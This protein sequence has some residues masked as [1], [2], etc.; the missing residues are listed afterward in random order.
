MKKTKEIIIEDGRDK[1]KKFRITEM[2]AYQMDRWATRA[3]LALGKNHKG[4][5]LAIVSMNP[6]DLLDALTE[7]DPEVIE[8][9]SQE[10]LECCSFIKDGTSVALTKEFIDS[11]VEDWK[12]IGKLRWEAIQLNIGFLEQGDGSDTE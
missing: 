9:L 5:I 11:I 3:L 10:M 8:P 6:K 1:G 7:A 4:G 2:P 12:T